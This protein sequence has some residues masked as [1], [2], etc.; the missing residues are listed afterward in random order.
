MI[1]WNTAGDREGQPEACVCLLLTLDGD[2]STGMAKLPHNC[3]QRAVMLM[4][5]ERLQQI[6]SCMGLVTT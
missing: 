6:P 3:R 4:D 5:E 2:L 1:W